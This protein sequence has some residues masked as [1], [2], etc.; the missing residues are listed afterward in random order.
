MTKKTRY[1]MVG[2]VAILAVGLSIGL[3]AYYGGLSGIALSRAA[4]P[5]ELRYIPK[6]AVVVAFVNVHD[7]MASEFRQKIRGLESAHDAKGQQEFREATGIDIENDIDHVVACMLPGD[8][9]ADKRGFVLASGRFNQARI[10]GFVKEHEGVVQSYKGKKV[11][12]HKSTSEEGTTSHAG[13]EGMAVAFIGP[14]LAA[15]GTISGVERAIDLEQGGESVA[16]NA[17]MMK[18]IRA[19]EDGNAWAVGRFDALAN[20]AKLP[21]HVASQIPPITWF[22]ASGRVDG[23]VSGTVSVE[24]RD[25]NAA[26]NLRDVVNGFVALARLQAGS[27]PEIQTLVQS[28]QLGGTDKTVAISF[29]VPAAMLDALKSEVASKKG[30]SKK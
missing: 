14:N 19:V 6:D 4:G 24:A 29:T 21:E 15:L 8:S 7:V 1:F 2:A 11:F 30:T 27:K 17:E 13:A 16:D 18:L 22:S 23:G 3:V 12:L 9:T 5:E 28:V 20:T 10:E 26:K 25:E